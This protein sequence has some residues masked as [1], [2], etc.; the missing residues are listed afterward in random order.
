[1][2]LVIFLY[3]FFRPGLTKK[4]NDPTAALVIFPILVGSIIFGVWPGFALMV[5]EAFFENTSKIRLIG[6]VK[7]LLSITVI[8]TLGLVVFPFYFSIKSKR[9]ATKELGS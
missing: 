4:N 7:F 9:L 1:M 6:D 5:G 3:E 2:V 8:I